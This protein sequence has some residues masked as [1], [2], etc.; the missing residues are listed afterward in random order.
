MLITNEN[1][2]NTIPMKEKTKKKK[3]FPFSQS[4]VPSMGFG[5]LHTTSIYMIDYCKLTRIGNTSHCRG[6]M[7]LWEIEN[8]LIW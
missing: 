1:P 3:I 7:C 2:A 5:K 8:R 4:M 6:Y